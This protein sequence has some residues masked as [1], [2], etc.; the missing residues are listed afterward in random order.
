MQEATI[1]LHVEPLAEGGYMASCPDVRGLRAYGSTIDQATRNAQ[2]V[3]KAWVESCREHGDPIP[4][5][6]RAVEDRIEVDL[7]V[8]VEVG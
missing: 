2:S 7:V 4:P 3:A 6:L 1:R 5:A 8:P